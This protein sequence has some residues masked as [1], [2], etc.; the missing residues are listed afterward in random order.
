M[1]FVFVDLQRSLN[2][3]V[4][5]AK[6]AHPS[7]AER[8]LNILRAP[9][10]IRWKRPALGIAMETAVRPIGY[11]RNVPVLHW[12]EMNV[13][14]MALKIRLISNRA[15]PIT[16]L[17]DTL[18]AFADFACGSRHGIKSSRKAALDQA[19]TYGEIVI[20]LRQRPNRVNVI[21]QDTD[22]NRFKRPALLNRPID[23]SQTINLIEQ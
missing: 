19:P 10:P 12:I 1:F 14:D 16:T 9:A 23:P 15:F 22:R 17:P 21:R 3:R 18:L 6:R 7:F 11:T 4:G 13:I 20:T 8:S 2:S 5:K